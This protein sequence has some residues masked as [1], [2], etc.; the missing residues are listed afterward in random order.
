MNR[1]EL[2]L[3]VLTE[4]SRILGST[5]ELEEIYNQIMKVLAEQMNLHCG[6]ILLLREGSERL[7]VAASYG[8]TP[9]E[10]HSMNLKIG[11]GVAGRVIQT[12]EALVVP[13]LSKEMG[14]VVSLGQRSRRSVSG[15]A[16]I[17]VPIITAGKVVGAL[18]VERPESTP[19][20]LQDD[21]RLLSI[22]AAMIA[23]ANRINQ[24]VR[25]EKEE[26][27][28]ENYY[29][30]EELKAKYK[31]DNI[32][33]VSK[34]MQEVFETAALVS[35]SK[36]SVL[37]RGETGT[38]KELVARAIHYNCARANQP[39][40]SVNCAALSESLLESE[41]FGHVKGSFTGAHAD[42]KGR[43]EVADR[44]TLFL[45]E[46][47]DMSPRLQVK[48]L[49][50][51]QEHEFERVGDT[52][53]MEVDVRVIAATNKNLEEEIVQAKFREDLY[54]RLNV[55]PIYIPPLRE[56]RE[57]IPLLIE[58]FLDKYNRENVKNVT[59]ISKEILDTLM[60]Y[61]WPG[62]VRELENCIER[63]VVMARGNQF[64][65]GALPFNLRGAKPRLGLD[66]LELSIEAAIK[67]SF[68]EERHGAENDPSDLF[69]KLIGK[70]EKALIEEVL[71]DCGFIQTLA[72]QRLGISRNTLHKKLLE[73][74]IPLRHVPRA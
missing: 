72:A 30:R 43:F 70:A 15:T 18:S 39:F 26:L 19:E 17:C 50:V 63:A 65:Y 57:D 47:G 27:I 48:L 33:G 8:L 44:G 56:R 25:L 5:F 16:F 38:G 37:I 29:L 61:P 24:M 2:E 41:L 21:Q 1:E 71:K 58:F 55:V 13:D 22:I 45:D 42:K 74:R 23:Q 20:E 60:D 52:A 51:L 31:F 59:Q 64:P 12:G 49:R 11:E 62:N 10:V 66:G 36:A 14:A 6:T 28:V 4:I 9:Q 40:V 73:H 69:S 34:G 53:T 3:T 32:I 54:F 7:K 68:L 35:Q 46:I 67:Q